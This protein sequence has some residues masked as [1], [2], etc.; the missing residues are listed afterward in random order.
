MIDHYENTCSKCKY[1]EVD[2]HDSPCKDC[3]KAFFDDWKNP[4]RKLPYFKKK[5]NKND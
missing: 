2:E 5:E 1:K 4:K 3:V